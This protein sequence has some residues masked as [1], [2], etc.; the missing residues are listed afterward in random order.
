MSEA[1]SGTHASVENPHI[2]SL[3]RA[4][5][6]VRAHCAARN[7]GTHHISARPIDAANMSRAC[8]NLDAFGRPSVTRVWGHG[9]AVFGPN[10][11]GVST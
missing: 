6:A 4:T 1:A 9:T 5:K 11:L 10:L 2:D 7:I 3:M 8:R